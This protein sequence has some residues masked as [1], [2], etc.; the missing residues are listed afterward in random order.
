MRRLFDI[1]ASGF[2]GLVLLPIAVLVAVAIRP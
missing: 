2:G 1:I